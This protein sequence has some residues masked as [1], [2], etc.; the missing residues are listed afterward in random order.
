MTVK[1]LLYQWLCVIKLTLNKHTYNDYLNYS[2]HVIDYIGDRHIS[3]LSSSDLQQ[4]FLQML[5]DH[6]ISYV[7]H[8][9]RIFRIAIH[10]ALDNDILCKD[11]LR[12]VKL[13]KQQKYNPV[14]L[15]PLEL[16]R[17]IKCSEDYGIYNAV[18]LAGCAGL[19]RGECL[20]L[21]VSDLDRERC[22]IRVSHS[23][24]WKNGK[25]IISSPK[26]ES[27]NR[28]L[29]VSPAF[30]QS[31]LDHTDS[32][33]LCDYSQSVLCRR[34]SRCLSENGFAH[35]RF[36]DLRHTFASLALDAGTN[37]KVLQSRMGHA[38]I[39][40]TLDTYA[41]LDVSAQAKSADLFDDFLI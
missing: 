10:Y 25:R 38:S 17:L 40:L 19:R 27:G 1:E 11:I 28:I 33:Y 8:A 41:H 18:I 32:D 34:L 13:P 6:G 3:G 5:D 30:I 36:H 12:S 2:N 39:R 35:M 21:A 20:A 9:H 37:I 15:S 4:M 22:L 14:F 24:E 23:A 29:M 16:K 26:S 7:I 31:L